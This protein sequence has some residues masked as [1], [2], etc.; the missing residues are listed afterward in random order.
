[1]KKYW[2][3]GAVVF[4]VFLMGHHITGSVEDAAGEALLL[5]VMAFGFASFIE[6]VHE[7]GE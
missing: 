4:G 7:E 6:Y 5:G 1:M 3:T 2:I